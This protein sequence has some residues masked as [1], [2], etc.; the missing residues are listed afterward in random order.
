VRF[1][2]FDTTGAPLPSP[3]PDPLRV[4]RVDVTF[5]ARTVVRAGGTSAD[6]VVARDSALL[7]VALRNR[8]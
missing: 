7:R 4:G 1:A 6:S 3:V 5:R 2:Y 8:I